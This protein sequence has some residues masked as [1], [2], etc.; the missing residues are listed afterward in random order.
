[1][2]DGEPVRAALARELEEELGIRVERA[3]P[4][5]QVRHDYADKH[6]LLD[7]WE[8]DG[9]SGE[10][11]GAEGQPL[12]WVEPRELADYEFPAANAPIVQAARLPAHYLITP[13]GLEPGELISGVRK[14]VEAGIRLIQLRAP[15]MFSPEYRDLAI[16]IQDS[17]PARRN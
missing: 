10:A 8:V 17:A 16:D 11:H 5:I 4:L 13:D 15:N 12:A 2:E 1:M 7:V 3:R 14:A 9:F 6:V